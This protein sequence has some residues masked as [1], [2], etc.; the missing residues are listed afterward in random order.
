MAPAEGEDVVGQGPDDTTTPSQPSWLRRAALVAAVLVAGAVLSRTGLLSSDQPA[1]APEPSPSGS[2]SGAAPGGAP[3]LVARVGDRLVLAARGAARPGVSLPPGL[4]GDAV[5]VPVRA[6]G[7]DAGAG[8][9][10]PGPVVGVVDG[11]L[12]RADP[13]RTRWRDLGSADSVVG[14]A[15]S[16]A[17]V[18]VDR[19]GSLQEVEVSTGSVV[20]PQPF[21]GFVP[22][23][24]TAQGLLGGAGVGSL[25]MSRPVGD[26]Q[27]ALALAAPRALVESGQREAVRDLGT[28][29]ELL[30]IADDWAV[31]LSPDCPGASCR[32]VVISVTR[33]TTQARAVSPPSGWTFLGGPIAGR[34]HEAL[35]PV[36]RID[37]G[38]TRTGEVAMARLVPGGDNALLVPGTD[39]VR[40]SADLADGPRGSVYL[41]RDPAGGG[42]PQPLVW[43]PTS[44]NSAVPVRPAGSFPPDSRLVCVCG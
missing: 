26:D 11:R 12:F 22:G 34:T 16:P 23:Q 21:P 7:N 30:G 27:T 6:G 39:R 19:D 25:L 32:L 36:G 38:G 29:G 20:D 31:T 24:W 10:A 18:I 14:A 35:V 8:A 43:D 37:P 2:A 41:L 44:P 42:D 13:G 9:D 40:L 3:R 4:P 15:L 28:Y 1:P 5:L 17:R 33:D